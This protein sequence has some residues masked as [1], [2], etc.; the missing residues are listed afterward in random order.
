[1]VDVEFAVQYLVLANANRIPELLANIGN[2]GLLKLA[3]THQLLDK[4]VAEKAAN[5]YRLLRERQHRFRLDGH[6]RSRVSD[7][8]MDQDILQA[9]QAVEQLWATVMR[10]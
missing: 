6:D 9:K 2:I 1:M 3:A 4:A 7:V 8:Q 10:V 5:A